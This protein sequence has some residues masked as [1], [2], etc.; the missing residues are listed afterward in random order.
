M[1]RF[2]IEKVR[3]APTKPRA[4]NINGVYATVRSGFYTEK[5]EVPVYYRQ[6][7]LKT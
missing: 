4:L 6:E 5:C 7:D 2:L 3:P 1:G